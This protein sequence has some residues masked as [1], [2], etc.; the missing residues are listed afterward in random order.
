M[1][2]LPRGINPLAPPW[3]WPSCAGGPAAPDASEGGRLAFYEFG[4]VQALTALQRLE[5]VQLPFDGDGCFRWYSTAIVSTSTGAFLRI[6]DHAGRYLTNDFVFSDDWAPAGSQGRPLVPYETVPAGA[7]W[8][9][10]FREAAG[11]TPTLFI[12]FRG[13]KVT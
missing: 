13:V 3:L 8:T 2:A 12:A 6:R 10:D 9:I 7:I 1:I 5:N 11:G 4:V